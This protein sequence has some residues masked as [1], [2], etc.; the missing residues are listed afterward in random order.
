MRTI[1]ALACAAALVAGLATAVAQSN[2][3]S[4]NVVGYYNVTL[5]PNQLYL[6]ANQLNTTNNTL[7]NVIPTAGEGSQLYKFVGGNWQSQGFSYGQ[8]DDPTWTLNPGEAVMLLDGGTGQTLTFVGE[9]L[10]GAQ[11][12]PVGLKLGNGSA[13][14]CFVSSMVPQQGTPTDFNVPAEEGDQMYVFIGTNWHSD[15]YSY[16]VWADNGGNGPTIN[17]GQGFAYL[18]AATSVSSTWTR[19]FTV[20]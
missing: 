2:V 19:N 14:I 13:N 6:I 16:G 8:W 5:T 7:G 3:Y 11:T 18:K 10:Q 4:L 1:K 15:G 12:N 20:Q 17:V 9:V